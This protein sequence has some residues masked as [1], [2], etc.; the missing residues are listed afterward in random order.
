MNDSIMQAAWAGAA[1]AC[2]FYTI[3]VRPR[4]LIWPLISLLTLLVVLDKAVDLQT[5]V[6]VLSHDWIRL[7]LASSG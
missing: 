2:V 3:Q 5:A 6:Y 7:A 4:G 1:G